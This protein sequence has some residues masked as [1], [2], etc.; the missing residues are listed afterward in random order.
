M[1]RTDEE[2]VIDMAKFDYEC[3]K[4]IEDFIEFSKVCEEDGIEATEELW[5]VYLNNYNSEPAYEDE[6][7]YLDW[8]EYYKFLE[9]LRRT[10]V[11]NMYGAA[12][13]LVECFND[14]FHEMTELKAN[15][16]LISWMNNYSE[17]DKKYGW[18]E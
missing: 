18:R 10:G 1:G 9:A 17:L 6:L 2:K 16:I 8:E 13:Y 3:G 11:C 14:P 12:K 15:N 7:D 4:P 5:Q